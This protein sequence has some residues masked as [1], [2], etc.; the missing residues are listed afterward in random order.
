V[1]FNPGLKTS[2]MMVPALIGLILVFVGTVATSLG[3]VPERQSGALEQLAV[4]PLG[5]PASGTPSG[6]GGGVRGTPGGCP[7]EPGGRRRGAGHHPLDG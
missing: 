6:R 7:G 4:M 2:V 3:V 5:P 1:L